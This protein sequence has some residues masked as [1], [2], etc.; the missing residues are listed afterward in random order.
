MAIVRVHAEVG[1]RCA[2]HTRT[3]ERTHVH[4]WY[5][6]VSYHAH[7]AASILYLTR[8]LT[9]SRKQLAI[10]RSATLAKKKQYYLVRLV[11]HS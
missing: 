11:W 5:V 10:A 6:V 4:I 9:L 1:S 7:F 3:H 2:T 8:P